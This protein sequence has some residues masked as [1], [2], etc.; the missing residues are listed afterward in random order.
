MT[1]P[2]PKSSESAKT[3]SPEELSRITQ[4][5]IRRL[6]TLE[7]AGLLTREDQDTIYIADP[8]GTWVIQRN[9][10]LA[11]GE[12]KAQAVPDLMSNT[13]RPVRVAIREG[14]TIQ[15]IRPW[16][17]RKGELGS[18][19]RTIAQKIFTLGGAP[20]PISERSVNK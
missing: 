2:D 8:Q 11:L 17:I 20:L 1:R 18:E 10:I 15:E 12:W 9:D 4:T 19:A 6:Q 7:F 16:Q 5:P 3:L 13:G 14:A